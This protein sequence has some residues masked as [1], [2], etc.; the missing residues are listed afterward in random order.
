MTPKSDFI[1]RFLTPREML[2]AHPQF[3]MKSSIL[4]YMYNTYQWLCPSM[5]R[6]LALR[7]LFVH[8]RGRLPLVLIGVVAFHRRQDPQDRN[9]PTAF[10]NLHKTI[11]SGCY[12]PTFPANE[13]ALASERCL[14]IGVVISTGSCRRRS[15]PPTTRSIGRY[16]PCGRSRSQR[17]VPPDQAM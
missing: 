3:R 16:D 13:A 5:A 7:S 1:S 10:S 17:H 15:V 14:F 2:N 8:R 4:R 12:Q 6:R 11:T 9:N